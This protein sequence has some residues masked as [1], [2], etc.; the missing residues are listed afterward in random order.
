MTITAEAPRGGVVEYIGDTSYVFRLRNREIERFEDKH[1]GI[2]DF[3]EGVFGRGKKPTS[4]EIRDIL[5]L[6][7]VGGGMKDGE[8]DKVIS[9]ATPADLMR[10]YQ[11][12]QA[13]IGV[14]FMPDA[15]DS[16]SKKKT[17]EDQD[18]TGSTSEA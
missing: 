15:V 5:A 9:A 3:W 11:I 4:T 18:L 14:A 7:L 16:A 1:R 2:F 13:V 17:P 10:L 12:A 8:A 6:A